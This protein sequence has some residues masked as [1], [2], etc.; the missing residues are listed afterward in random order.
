MEEGKRTT[1]LKLQRSINSYYTQKLAISN[2]RTVKL[3]H[4]ALDNFEKFTKEFYNK[5]LDEIT[6]EFKDEEVAY[7]V[8]QAWI[9]WNLLKRSVK[10]TKLYF[11]MVKPYLYYK[12]IKFHPLDIKQNLKFPKVLEDEKHGVTQDEIRKIFDYLR[13]RKKALYLCQSSSGMRIGELMRLRKSQL[14]LDS[15]RIV[16]YIPAEHSKN[17]RARTTFFSKEAEKYLKVI[18]KNLD[19]NDLIFTK[20]E[21]WEYARNSEITNMRRWIK[22]C[23]LKN[24]TTH[25]FRAYFITK[26]SRTDP[27]V[28]KRLAGQKG[29]LDTYDRLSLEEK[30][31]VYLK[32]E[33]LLLI[34]DNSQN[35]P[36]RITKLEK[37][38]SVMFD[39]I[40]KMRNYE[41]T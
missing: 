39:T 5:S 21:N 34:F 28:A 14:N 19:E 31:E 20:N 24:I 33:P 11:T 41:I 22:K 26:V 25:S 10:T 38:L 15:K 16:V 35:D 4:Y 30:L 17:G 37:K 1:S 23:G 2:P 7:D 29:Y 12:G 3:A 9:N 27:N 13:P 36:D 32:V 40:Q 8:L 18:I 6:E